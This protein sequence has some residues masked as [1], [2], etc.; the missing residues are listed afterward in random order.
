MLNIIILK[1]KNGKSTRRKSGRKTKKE[2]RW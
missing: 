2:G 1:K